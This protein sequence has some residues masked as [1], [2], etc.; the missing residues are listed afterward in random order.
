MLVAVA[1]G[2]MTLATPVRAQDALRQDF[3]IAAGEL[4]D[5]LKA[6]SR[7][8]GRDIIFTAQAVRGKTA[9]RIKGS[10]TPDEAVRALLVGSSLTAE[11]RKDVVLIRGRSETPGQIE[12][13]SAAS[14]DIVVTG[15]RIA[16]APSPSQ[17]IT[18]SRG[19]MLNAGKST[20]GDVVRDIPQNFTGGQNPSIAGTTPSSSGESVGAGTSINLRG[21]GQDATL[22]LLNGNRLASGGARQSIDVSSIPL[23]AVERI[24]IVADGAS[25]LY[26]SD[27][28]AGVANIILR[29]DFDGIASGARF[30]AATDGGREQQQYSLTA[31]KTWDRAGFIVA[32]EYSHETPIEFRQRAYAAQTNAGLIL[33]PWIERHSALFSGHFE[34]APALTLA[35]DGLY[36]S[37]ADRRGYLLSTSS[38]FTNVRYWGKSFSLA[39]SLTY[40]AGHNWKATLSGSYGQDHTRY[41]TTTETP[42]VVTPILEACYC[43]AAKSAEL[44]AD[45]PLFPLPAGELKVAIG[46]GYRHADFHAFRTIGSTPQNI[47]VGQDTYYAF[48]ELSL[49]IISPEQGSALGHSLRLSA[50]LRYEDYPGVDRVATPKLGA[51]YAP[52]EGLEIKA[53]WGK[54][55]KAPTLYQ[56]YSDQTAFASAARNYGA[57]AIPATAVAIQLVGGRPDLQSERATTWSASLAFHP[58]AVPGLDIEI[59]YFNIRYRNRVIAPIAITSQA[60]SNSAYASLVVLNPTTAQVADIL[61]GKVFLN[62]LGVPFNPADVVA[63]VDNRNLNV[64]SQRIQGVDLAARYAM[65]LGSSKFSLLGNLSYLDST[66]ALNPA[67]PQLPL[68][69]TI[70]NPPHIRARG[71]AIWTFAGL[72][73]SAYV[74]HIGGLDDTRRAPTVPISGMTTLDLTARYVTSEGSGP[75]RNIEITLSAQNFLNVTP[76]AA[77]S[78]GIYDPPYDSTNFNPIGRF[79]SFAISKKW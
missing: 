53:S 4:S 8:S 12:E 10:F 47:D 41:R 40:E 74:N 28:V 1:L 36:G 34:V 64:A 73:A 51:I 60:L 76:P 69:G 46:G 79:V 59:G 75:L 68:S 16:G 39:P 29:R 17:T 32:Y 2:A 27:A 50:A 62:G 23:G 19:E 31:G 58:R 18:I 44:R 45:G 25:A 9:P 71:G 57:T 30:G 26:G 24:E 15:S 7:Q 54:S 14:A 43:N 20:L 77:R 49:P 61:K 72:T 66:Q 55:F 22:T 21:L 13:S 35:L 67:Q 52:F 3:S 38:P 6:V 63:I 78:V 5:A 65:D 11:F 48:G 33:Y 56:Q 70:Y 37:R 42:T